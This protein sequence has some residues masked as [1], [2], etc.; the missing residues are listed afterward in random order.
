MNLKHI[1]KYISFCLVFLTLVTSCKKEEK[2]YLNAARPTVLQYISQAKD[3][4]L[5]YLAIRH[6]GLEKDNSFLTEGPFTLFAPVDSAFAGMGFTAEKIRAFDPAQLATLLKYNIVKGRVSSS[7]LLGFYSQQV[8]SLNADYEPTITKNYYGIFF[9][10]IPFVEANIELGDGV[11]HKIS[12]TSFPPVKNLWEL[13]NADPELSLYVTAVNKEAE[14]SGGI[15]NAKYYIQS[16]PGLS[17]II[18]PNNAAFKIFGYQSNA[19]VEQASLK[20][21]RDMTY[22]TVGKGAK[23]TSDYLGGGVVSAY[24]GGQICLIRE[25]GLTITSKGNIF[26]AKIVKP[27]LLATNGVVHVLNQLLKP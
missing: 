27:N 2:E 12:K 4:S 15:F 3:L 24:I 25:D 13:I 23:F 14:L 9:N 16:S 20:E 7:S 22:I 19:D 10:G 5:F 21:L 18:A 17:T 1:M 8:K 11:V 26:D 6:S